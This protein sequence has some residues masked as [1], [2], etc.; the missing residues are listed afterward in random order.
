MIEYSRRPKW[1]AVCG[2]PIPPGKAYRADDGPRC[3]GH[4]QSETS[5]QHTESRGQHG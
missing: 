1:C 2:E 4:D 3:L 5:N